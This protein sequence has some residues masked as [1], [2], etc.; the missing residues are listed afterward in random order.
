ME[1]PTIAD[2]RD[3]V[4]RA[5]TVVTGAAALI[6]GFS[7][8]VQAAVDAALANGATAAQLAPL[9]A[10]IDAFDAVATDLASAVAENV[11]S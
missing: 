5:T 8:R 10:E 3:T 7:A 2:V 9:Q 1:N 6:R 11:G 4:A